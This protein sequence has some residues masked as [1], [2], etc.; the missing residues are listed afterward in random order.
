MKLIQ[1]FRA[2]LNA[3]T[4]VLLLVIVS[5]CSTD[6]MQT[7]NDETDSQDQQEVNKDANRQSTGSSSEALLS[8]KSFTSIK[9]EIQYMPGMEPRQQTIDNFRTFLE[10]RLNKP[11]GI[12]LVVE[13]IPSAN[14]DQYSIDDIV[15]LENNYRTAYNDDRMIA[16]W[17]IFLD[18][19]YAGNTENGTVLG[20]AFR[21][22]SFALFESSV[23]EF[24]DRA[25]APSR[26]VLESTV[27]NH[28]FGHLMGLVNAGAP[29]QSDHQDTEHGRH[30]TDENCLMYWTAETGEGI[31]DMLTGGNIP[32]L[33]TQCIADL[34]ANGGK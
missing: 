10:E 4:F 23:Q 17:G 5:S 16:V 1:L 34:R 28:E 12:E 7:G 27:L 14:K 32:S 9:L 11:A 20:V 2:P 33:D 8:D 29:L 21:N 3:I 26:T 31:L 19:E 25:F 18:A 24:S 6:A 13:E 22:T 30:C 15:S